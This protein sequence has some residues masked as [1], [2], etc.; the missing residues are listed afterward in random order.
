MI[1]GLG[2]DLVE[3]DRI[4]HSLERFGHHFLDK[5]LHATEKNALPDAHGITTAQAVAH[6]AGRFAA[7]EAAAKALG[8]GFA[9]GI[10]LHDIRVISQASGKPE[11]SFHGA[12]HERAEALSVTGVHL[13]L[14]HAQTHAGAVVILES[15][16]RPVHS[17][18]SPLPAS[19]AG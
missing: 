6:V 19:S 1:I 10:S 14:S 15:D 13:S 8:T 11:L 16:T 2:I 9:A 18:F 5:L 12:A 3:L 4:R 7:K 17:R